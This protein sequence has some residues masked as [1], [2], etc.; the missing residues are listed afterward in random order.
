MKNL[1]IKLQTTLIAVLAVVGFVITA[2]IYITSNAQL[3]S[4][5]E[6]QDAAT[7]TLRDVETI[8][9]DF[10][11]ARGNEK[12]FLNRLSMEDVEAH[13]TT[14]ERVLTNLDKLHTRNKAPEFQQLVDNVQEYY[15]TYVEQFQ[16]VQEIWVEVG[17]TPEEGLRGELQKV[18]QQAEDLL[19]KYSDPQLRIT[20]LRMRGL[21][22]DFLIQMQEQHI[23]D[24]VSRQVE[25]TRQLQWS[26]IPPEEKTKLQG[27]LD[28]YHELFNTLAVNQLSLVPATE[29]LSNLFSIAA[30]ELQKLVEMSQTEMA[31]ARQTANS[32]MSNT[33]VIML[34]AMVV[35]AILVGVAGL[36]IGNGI[37]GPIGRITDVMK[38]L[39]DEDLSVDIPAQQRRNEIGIMASAVAVFK[40]N[41]IKAKELA[42]A[43][44]AEQ[45]E[46]M[47]RGQ[48]LED[49]IGKFESEVTHI[50]ESVSHGAN[51]IIEIAG[52]M[53]NK[54]D[55]SAS[56]SLDVAEASGRTTSNVSTVSA[57][58]EE[59]SSSISEISRQVSRGSQ[60]SAEAEREATQTI[61][62]VQSLSD[63]AQ[64]IGE[65]VELITDIADQ[66]NLLAL[67]A[68]IEAARAGDAG[69]GFAVVASEVK[70]LA[71]QTAKA[72]EEIGIQIA[73]I[74]NAT[75]DSAQSIREFGKTIAQISE[76]SSATAAA[77]EEQGA[78][79]QEI[80]RNIRDVSD[81]A[82]LVSN[83]V[84]DVSRSSASSYSS[85][86]QVLWKGQDMTRPTQEL[87]DVVE[88]FLQAVRT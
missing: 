36:F 40:D 68:T 62:K 80:A 6:S 64:K 69:K 15:Q 28:T 67:N 87:R 77:V 57:A 22:K 7:E 14:S 81:D 78:A 52:K 49:A 25:F 23:D 10:L 79:T 31:T 16:E 20:M 45:A 8:K 71:N 75:E 61:K 3:H 53:G 4:A 33:A 5:L 18:V 13:K 26:S 66:T 70:N 76:S 9:Y 39:A 65:V 12:D 82:Q 21:E 38:R 59:L 48:I 44:Q 47:R 34:G 11:N 83:A 73:G 55:K 35:V 37:S 46:K 32:T 63:A 54:I 43:Q 30:P 27:L 88:T 50:V 84:A 41:M 51:N 60:M 85:A 58:A 2:I 17:L 42:V 1:A 72:T 19:S 74:Q 86:I 24:M 29:E 56:R